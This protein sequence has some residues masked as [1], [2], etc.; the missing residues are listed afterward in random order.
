M[1][2]INLSRQRLK[3]IPS[4]IGHLNKV[5][6]RNYIAKNVCDFSGQV[7]VCN[8]SGNDLSSSQSFPEEFFE[9]WRLKELDLSYNRLTEVG[10]DLSNVHTLITIIRSNHSLRCP[11]ASAL[12][13]YVS[14][15][16][17]SEHH[18]QRVQGPPASGIYSP[19]TK[20]NPLLI[21]TPR[22]LAV[23]LYGC[24]RR[25]NIPQIK[26]HSRARLDH[27]LS[28]DGIDHARDETRDSGL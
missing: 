16:S 3:S 10:R 20:S 4:Q 7:E 17:S 19:R 23:H 9:L 22:A 11:T 18:W 13:L 25:L 26:Y 24:G 28:A 8:L 1:L 14:G 27:M 6:I 12:P 2:N 21:R 15:P 5:E